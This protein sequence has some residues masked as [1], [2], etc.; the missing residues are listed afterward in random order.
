MKQVAKNIDDTDNT[1]TNG[2]YYYYY[3][4]VTTNFRGKVSIIYKKK[5]EVFITAVL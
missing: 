3:Y 5:P 2:Y 4:Y 1:S